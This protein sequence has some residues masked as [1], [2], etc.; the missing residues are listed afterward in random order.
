[1]YNV[2]VKNVI[3]VWKQVDMKRNQKNVDHYLKTVNCVYKKNVL[4]V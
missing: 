1:M 4:C 2:Y 3:S